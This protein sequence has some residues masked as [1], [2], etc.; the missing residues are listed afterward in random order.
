[1]ST[2]EIINYSLWGIIF[3]VIQILL[4]Q[5]I[6]L[7]GYAFCFLYIGILLVLPIETDTSKVMLL[8]LSIGLIVDVFYNTLGMHAAASVLIA[9]LRPIWIKM[10]IDVKDADRIDITLDDLG[11]VRFCTL[12][13]PLIFLHHLALFLIE[14]NSLVLLPYTVIKIVASSLFTMIALLLSQSFRKA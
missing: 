12:T 5:H 2:K 6:V 13:F 10:V 9:Y 11:L 3:I 4:L 14:I 8:G 1:M 7:F